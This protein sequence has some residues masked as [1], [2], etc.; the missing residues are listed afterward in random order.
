MRVLVVEPCPQCAPVFP[1]PARV[2]DGPDGGPR[3]R[4]IAAQRMFP[5]YNVLAS[6][7]LFRCTSGTTPTTLP[8][9]L[10]ASLGLRWASLVL[11]LLTAGPYSHS[12]PNS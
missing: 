7:A 6:C 10:W 4:D 3:T 9:P 1:F 5:P 8:R 11:P 12:N 2:W